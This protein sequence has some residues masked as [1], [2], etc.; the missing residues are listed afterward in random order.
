MTQ[1]S[2]V[3]KD[4]EIRHIPP[5]DPSLVFTTYDLGCSVALICA[6]FEL[7]TLDKA[8]QRKVLLVFKR[9]D[10]IES[11]VD[12]YWSDRLEVKA[13]TYFDTLKMLKN[14]LYSE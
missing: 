8:N 10:G 5:D 13:R 2:L 14:R 9:E 1:D 6:G 7:L 12:N 11:V 3:Q 4:K